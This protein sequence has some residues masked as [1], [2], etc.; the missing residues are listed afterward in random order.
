MWVSAWLPCGPLI[1]TQFFPLC[2]CYQLPPSFISILSTFHVFSSL[3][4]WS[5][6]H[7]HLHMV[8]S[9][10]WRSLTHSTHHVLYWW[11]L[12]FYFCL[13]VI[14]SLNSP[15]G[16]QFVLEVAP[17]SMHCTVGCHLSPLCIWFSLVLGMT[18]C[19]TYHVE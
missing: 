7:I 10:Y 13:M 6:T 1:K 4:W 3:Y 5:P 11:M 15:Y 19:S 2:F 8:F 9:L 17:P 14:N 18:T 12:T 16:F